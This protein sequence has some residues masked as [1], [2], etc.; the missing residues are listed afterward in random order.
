MCRLS[1]LTPLVVCAAC[2]I[3]PPVVLPVDATKSVDQT[4]ECALRSLNDM[5]YT[6]TAADR[7][8]GFVRARR[9]R[10]HVFGSDADYDQ[11]TVSVYRAD[12]GHTML[13]V[14]PAVTGE[15]EGVTPP[16]DDGM[17]DQTK[18][19]ARCAGKAPATP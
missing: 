3:N 15:H 6:I 7:A 9:L 4:Y 16:T 2:I 12:D 19:V 14:V 18:L 10:S 1:F 17:K 8:S 13:R 5:Q 11:Q